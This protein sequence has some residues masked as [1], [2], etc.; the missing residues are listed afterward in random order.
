MVG[1]DTKTE[2]HYDG[3][4]Q[5]IRTGLLANL[6]PETAERVTYRNAQRSGVVGLQ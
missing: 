6:K 5:T 4:I 2:K 3:G 1:T